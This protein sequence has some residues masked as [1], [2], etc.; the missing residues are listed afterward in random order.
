MTYSLRNLPEDFIA[1]LQGLEKSYRVE[2]DP[3]LQSGFTGALP[4]VPPE[5]IALRLR[6]CH[7]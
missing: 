4:P 6:A 3:I 1:K 2:S 7:V 5:F